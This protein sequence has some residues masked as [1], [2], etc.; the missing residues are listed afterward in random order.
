MAASCDEPQFIRCL[1]CE[2]NTIEKALAAHIQFN[3]MIYKE[4]VQQVIFNLHYP[5][6]K[7]L[8]LDELI[9][10]AEEEAKKKNDSS[11]QVFTPFQQH[12]RQDTV[13]KGTREKEKRE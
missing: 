2:C 9:E 3:H 7:N 11:E 5:P 8:P 10:M 1:L 12:M 13:G 6:L 4:A